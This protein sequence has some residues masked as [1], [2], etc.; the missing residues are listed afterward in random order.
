MTSNLL[1]LSDT[2]TIKSYCNSFW[3]QVTE[4]AQYNFSILLCLPPTQQKTR[5]SCTGRFISILRCQTP[6]LIAAGEKTWLLAKAQLPGYRLKGLTAT[7]PASKSCQCRSTQLHDWLRSYCL[8]LGTSLDVGVSQFLKLLTVYRSYKMETNIFLCWHSK[9][10]FTQKSI[11]FLTTIYYIDQKH[12]HCVPKSTNFAGS[13]TITS[14]LAVFGRNPL[15]AARSDTNH[16]GLCVLWFFPPICSVRCH[17]Q[18]S[19]PSA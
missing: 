18:C 1:V 14:S 3:W 9:I 2:T 4:Q 17:R 5:S 19:D 8:R 13:S 12:G 11:S 6:K 16:S 10:V 15:R 7:V